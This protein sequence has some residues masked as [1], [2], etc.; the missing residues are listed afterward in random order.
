MDLDKLPES[1]FR[2]ETGDYSIRSS[3]GGRPLANFTI[4]AETHDTTL[5]V[6]KKYPASAASYQETAKKVFTRQQAEYIRYSI[7][8]PSSLTGHATKSSSDALA[9]LFG[10]A[11]F[12]IRWV[13]AQEALVAEEVQQTRKLKKSQA[14]W[15]AAHVAFQAELDRINAQKQ[16]ALKSKF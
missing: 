9:K 15:Q 11:D 5:S 7:V 8:P 14:I 1:E 3:K 13:K 6:T 2:A 4:T 10:S 16:E 12:F